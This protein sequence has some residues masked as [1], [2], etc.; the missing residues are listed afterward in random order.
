MK[1]DMK[2]PLRLSLSPSHTCVVPMFSSY[3][4]LSGGFYQKVVFRWMYQHPVK[5]LKK[6]II[7]KKEHIHDYLMI[8]SLFIIPH[9]ARHYHKIILMII[10]CMDYESSWRGG[11]VLHWFHRITSLTHNNH[12]KRVASGELIERI[13]IQ[14]FFK[15]WDWLC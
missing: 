1:C 5:R 8:C 13:L 11:F 14:D 15:I 4:M 2:I 9:D 7:I 10:I 12:Y 3:V 6:L